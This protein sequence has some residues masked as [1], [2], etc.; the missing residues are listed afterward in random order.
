[1]T[2]ASRRG[3]GEEEGLGENFREWDKKE[4]T[5]KHATLSGSRR[6]FPIIGLLVSKDIF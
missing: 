1:M 6:I 5:V 3:K 2:Q 4:L